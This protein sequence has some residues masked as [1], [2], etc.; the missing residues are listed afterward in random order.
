MTT[1]FT[2]HLPDPS[3]S[4]RGEPSPDPLNLRLKRGAKHLRDALRDVIAGV[5]APSTRP[6]EFARVLKAHRVVVGRLL[7]AV[8]CRDPL[9]ALCEMPQAEGLRTILKASKSC[10]GKETIARASQAIA[11]M[12]RLLDQELGGW[13]ALHGVASDWLPEAR[14]KFEM[15]NKQA[16]YKG[17]ANIMGFC[18]DTEFCGFVGYP[19]E[20]GDRVDAALIAG[21]M[22][23]RRMRP[24][25]EICF[26]HIGTSPDDPSPITIEGVSTGDR[27][28]GYPLLEPFCSSPLPKF[29]VFRSERRAYYILGGNGVGPAS[30]VDLAT[31]CT[32]KGLHPRYQ[33]DPPRRIPAFGDP[34]VPCKSLIIDIL[35][36]EDVWPNA[37]PELI[38]YNT[39]QQEIANPNS[40]GGSLHQLPVTETIAYLGKGA[41]RFR[42]AEVGH[43]V[44]MI[45]FVCDRLGW[46]SER[47]RGYR[48]HIRYPI[49]GTNACI[50]LDPPPAPTS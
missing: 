30:A 5:P 14:K 1:A 49:V 3:G 47:L 22:G 37:T 20:T 36:H 38:M 27:T 35:L 40:P 15:A 25:A 12:E 41:A 50:V 34:T 10:V 48:C 11:D 21:S 23:L 4:L 31:A 45:Q 39:T 33:T 46:D 28:G 6:R 13:G 44:E 9:A 24:S 29:N 18:A 7:K 42:V 26:T 19:D 32:M 8:E 17:M 2:D 16:I 43:Y